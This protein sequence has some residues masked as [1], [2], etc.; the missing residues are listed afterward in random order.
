MTV[1]LE[2]DASVVIIGIDR[3]AIGEP[4][5][6][7]Q[8]IVGMICPGRRAQESTRTSQLNPH[9]I[10]RHPDTQLHE[11]VRRVLTKHHRTRN[12]FAGKQH[13]DIA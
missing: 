7:Q 6:E 2:P 8:V 12:K 13:D 4:V 10:R 11:L 5:N 3:P 1:D 9:Q